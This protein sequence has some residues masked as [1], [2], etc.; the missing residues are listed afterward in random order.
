[1]DTQIITPSNYA[2]EYKQRQ[3]LQQTVDDDFQFAEIGEYIPSAE[4]K[5]PLDRMA[6][7]SRKEQQTKFPDYVRF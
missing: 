3:L 4:L 2:E 1:M 7:I 5:A 6:E